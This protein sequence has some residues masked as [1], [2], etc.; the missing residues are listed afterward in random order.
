MIKIREVKA[1]IKD[2]LKI[3]I[4]FND[5]LVRKNTIEAVHKLETTNNFAFDIQ[6]RQYSRGGFILDNENNI[7]KNLDEIKK[8]IE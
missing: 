7:M 5:I 2:D 3:N 8:L 4:K 6:G 1:E